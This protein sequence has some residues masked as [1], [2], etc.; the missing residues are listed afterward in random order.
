MMGPNFGLLAAEVIGLVKFQEIQGLLN[1][2]TGCRHRA[3]VSQLFIG[4]GGC[5]VLFGLTWFFEMHMGIEDS[6][7]SSIWPMCG[8][9]HQS[10]DY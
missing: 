4:Q 9:C 7:K 10:P 6:M 8:E 1:P 2:S 3:D 5:R